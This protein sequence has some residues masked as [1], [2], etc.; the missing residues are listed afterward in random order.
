MNRVPAALD[1]LR[2][3]AGLLDQ[4]DAGEAVIEVPE[5]DGGDAPL[6]VHLPVH[7][8]GVVRVHLQLTQLLRGQVGVLHRR[9][10]LIAPGRSEHK[11]E[12]V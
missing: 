12:K 2:P 7:V 1:L 9:V 3:I 11:M 8:E 10:V 4:Y 5:I 6:E